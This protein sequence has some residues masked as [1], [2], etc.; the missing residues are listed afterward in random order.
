MENINKKKI[1]DEHLEKNNLE[2]NK[3]YKTFHNNEQIINNTKTNK[4]NLKNSKDKPH[5]TE[6]PINSEIIINNNNSKKITINSNNSIFHYPKNINNTKY[7]NYPFSSR[8]KKTNINNIKSLE[9]SLKNGVKSTYNLNNRVSRNGT[10]PNKTSIHNIINGK[11]KNSICNTLS[12]NNNKKSLNGNN[13]IKNNSKEKR[14]VNNNNYVNCNCK[15]IKSIS[16]NSIGNKNNLILNKM[17]INQEKKK[18]N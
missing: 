12:G 15:K 4:N 7:K 18:M 10:N 16:C 3:C 5:S 2:E 11:R 13:N 6:K 14:I 9:I 1:G 8:P 17:I